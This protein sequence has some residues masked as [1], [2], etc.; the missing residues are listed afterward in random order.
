MSIVK[1][2]PA[3][4]G[5]T[6]KL[7]IGSQTVGR[8]QSISGRRSFGTENQYEIGSIMPQESVPL[9]VEGT[10]TLEKYRIRKKSLAELGLSSYGIGI[11][12]MGLIDIKVT[13]KY[14][15][16]TIIVY[17]NCTLQESS[18]DF[19]ANAMAG[20]NATWLYLSADYGTA[21]SDTTITP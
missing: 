20:E 7:T 14:T 2:Q 19:R 17:R 13:D 12:N 3:H 18:E 11:L 15:D 21:E 10:V 4:A 8:A 1:D 6:I 5:H 16:E 9:R